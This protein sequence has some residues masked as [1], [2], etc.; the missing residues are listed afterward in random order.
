MTEYQKIIE[1][2]KTIPAD[3]TIK[4]EI[5]KGYIDKSIEEA[6]YMP[7]WSTYR[8]VKYRVY[9]LLLS[10]AEDMGMEGIDFI[11]L[12]KEIEHPVKE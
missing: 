3:Q 5:P 10:L 2:L 12:S 11:K 8:D 1:K 6:I 9:L 7:F 4:K